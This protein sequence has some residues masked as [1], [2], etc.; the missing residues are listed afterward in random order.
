[1]KKGMGPIAAAVALAAAKLALRYAAARFLDG[2]GTPGAK[3]RPKHRPRYSIEY[4]D[5]DGL[6]TDRNVTIASVHAENGVLYVTSYC[7]LRKA[8][9][10]FRADRILTMRHAG[11]KAI[12]DPVA[13]LNKAPHRPPP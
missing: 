10:I 5:A 8:P 3:D 13:F 11:G 6:V 7:D 4:G 9:R 2:G 12:K 1:M